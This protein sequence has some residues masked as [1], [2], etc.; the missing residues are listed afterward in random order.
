VIGTPN[1]DD[2][3]D[4]I[5]HDNAKKYIKFFKPCKPVDLKDMYPATDDK[6]LNL[7][8]KM[9]KFNPKKRI[10]AKEALQ[11]E[12]FDDIRIEE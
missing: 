9:L 7:L 2:D 3:L 12:Y 5:K 10:G 8:E 1:T 6:G 4:F 11:D